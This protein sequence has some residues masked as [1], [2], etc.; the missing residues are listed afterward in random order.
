MKKNDFLLFASTLAFSALFYQQAPGINYLLF[1]VMVTVVSLFFNSVSLMENKLWLYF[2]A[3]NLSGLAVFVI[4]SDLS[5]LACVLSL[6]V[7]SSK[8][9]NKHNSTLLCGVLGAFSVL[10]SVFYFFIAFSEQHISTSTKKNN[11]TLFLSLAVSVLISVVFFTLYKNS[12]PLFDNF[13]QFINLKW[14]SFGWVC[15]T[16]FGFFV[17]HG[18]YLSKNIAALNTLD[19]KAQKKIE[20]QNTQNQN[21][22]ANRVMGYILFTVLNLMLLVLNVLDINNLFISQQMPPGITLSDFVHEAVWN[23]IGSIVLAVGLILWL[24][25][26]DLNFTQAGKNIRYLVYTWILQSILVVFNAIVRNM[27]YVTEYQLSQQRIGVFVFLALC[28]AGLI[29]TYFKL[30]EQ[31]SAWRLVTKNVQLW[32]MT[33]VFLSLFNW[34]KLITSYNITH[35]SPKKALDKIYLLGLSDANIPELVDLHNAL[36]FD[37]YE[38]SLFYQKCE[39]TYKKDRF[40]QWPSFNLRAYQNQKAMELLKN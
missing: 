16:L 21:N 13:T 4:N 34:D 10:T 30:S 36:K 8:L 37:A 33:L 32:F 27:W 25:R 6:L 15:F 19:L 5:L 3:C 23:T 35:S 11:W 31:Q 39:V 1:T 9:L 12:N 20:Y 26:G 22:Q 18:L 7:Y 14:L 28:V 17:L 29:F 38:D 2:M 24:F 40:R